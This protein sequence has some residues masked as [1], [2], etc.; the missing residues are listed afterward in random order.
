MSIHDDGNNLVQ[1]S[2]IFKL[3]L[4]KATDEKFCQI[5]NDIDGISMY[6]NNLFDRNPSYKEVARETVKE[7]ID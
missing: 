4:S 5:S 3:I 1:E 2:G 7:Y 6:L